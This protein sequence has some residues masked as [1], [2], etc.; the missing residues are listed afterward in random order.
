MI[1]NPAPVA[2]LM[3]LLCLTVMSQEAA[4]ICGEELRGVVNEVK[5]KAY[6]WRK[7]GNSDELISRANINL[8]LHR[9]DQLKCAAGGELIITVCGNRLKIT[10]EKPY[11]L[12]SIDALSPAQRNAARVIFDSFKSRSR[13]RSG[14]FLLFPAEDNTSVVRPDTLVIRWKQLDPPP[15]PLSLRIMEGDEVLWK[16]ENID[17]GAGELSSAEIREMLNKLRNDNSTHEVKLKI[18]SE[19]GISMVTFRVLSL[20]DERSLENELSKYDKESEILRHMWRAYVY[21]QHGLAIDAAA[22]YEA[23]LAAAPESI[24]VREAAIAIQ[25][26]AGDQ[27]REKEL[28]LKLPKGVAPT[29]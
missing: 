14:D 6:L 7:N 26:W 9:G 23:V 18:Q 4:N 27:K 29:R 8:T 2:T 10:S 5:G 25:K 11:P 16:R 1:S 19:R 20:N 28:E 21:N 3:L 22:E 15:F 17:S 12:S 24:E 13:K